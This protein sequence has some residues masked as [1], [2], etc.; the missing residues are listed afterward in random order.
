MEM[1]DSEETVFNHEN[2]NKVAGT[3][4][5]EIRTTSLQ[6]FKKKHEFS[7]EV[8]LRKICFFRLEYYPKIELSEGCRFYRITGLSWQQFHVALVA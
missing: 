4:Y 6:L 2:L 3:T 8:F 7:S 5:N 1:V